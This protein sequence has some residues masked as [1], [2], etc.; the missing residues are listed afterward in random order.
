[1]RKKALGFAVA[2]LLAATLPTAL[3]STSAYAATE[4]PGTGLA[5]NYDWSYLVL[6]DGGWP[7]TAN[8]LT[9]M[10]QWME[11]E[12]PATDWWN[13][14]NPLNNGLGSGGGSGLGSYAN[15]VNAA[16]YVAAN[17]EYNGFGY[18]AIASDLAASAA[19]RVTAK[20]IWASS[21]ASG[22]YG[23]GK[24]WFTGIVMTVG[25][26]AKAWGNGAAVI[27]PANTT[28]PG[29]NSGFT[30][31]GPPQYW[32]SRA[33]F[34]L[35]NDARW[36]YSNGATGANGATWAPTLA[37]GTYNVL[38]FVPASFANASVTYVVRDASGMH[39]VPI[40]QAPY[41]DKW[42]PLGTFIAVSASPIS[43]HVGNTG[44]DPV[45]STYVGVDAMQFERTGKVSVYPFGTIGPGAPGFALGGPPQTWHAGAP[46]G[47]RGDAQWATSGGVSG[48]ASAHWTPTLSP[49]TYGV[50]AFV[51][52]KNATANVTYV[53]TDSLGTHN[54]PVY[55]ASF[56]NQW[57]SLGQFTTGTAGSISVRLTNASTDLVASTDV[58][59]DAVTF[60]NAGNLVLP[61]SSTRFESTPPRAAYGT[62]VSF[63]AIVQGI[64]GAPA[65]AVTFSIGAQLLCTAQLASGTA[66]CQSSYTPV[67][68][69]LVTARYLGSSSFAPSATTG[70]QVIVRSTSTTKVT[71]R[72]GTIPLGG[73]VT[74]DVA[75]LGAGAIPSGAARIGVNG[76]VVC[77]AHLVSGTGSCSATTT[78]R[79]RLVVFGRY[80]GDGHFL[81][82][83]A[84]SSLTVT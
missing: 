51:P 77:T 54:V 48:S 16:Y 44:S 35:E 13:R 76:T 12:E 7:S 75:V 81:H 46:Y 40:D 33:P 62:E 3:S 58:S 53:V 52:S 60:V 80:L 34:G 15:V 65:G 64:G 47:L 25:A 73:V 31:N 78:Q 61:V 84:R 29:A 18:P 23:H 70:S 10:T 55:Q 9:V 27:Y 71:V 59:A 66:T 22:H 17:L 38:A 14:N 6:Q 57:V 72:P 8:N 20:A 41:A 36:T 26:P 69:H 68:T 30:L 4:F 67:G 32:H 42:V 79:G 21:W 82:S 74:Y 63:S 5:T 45:A 56:P 2:S 1:M 43:V 11:S 37:P 28:G 39:K 83:A 50:Q 49:G 24:N 19:P